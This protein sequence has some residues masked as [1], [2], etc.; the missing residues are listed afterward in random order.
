MQFLIVLCCVSVG[1]VEQLSEQLFNYKSTTT[2]SRTLADNFRH[3]GDDG[4]IDTYWC[5]VREPDFS[6]HR[7]FV[8]SLNSDVSMKLDD[9]DK[10]STPR[11]D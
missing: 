8:P 7:R 11:M 1:L 9:A 10:P 3:A 6:Y 5:Y 4:S 2:Q